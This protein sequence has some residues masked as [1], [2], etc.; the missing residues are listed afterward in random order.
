MS[1]VVKRHYP[2]HKL[3]DDLQEA[4]AGATSVSVTLERDDDGLQPVS[5]DTIRKRIEGYRQRPDFKPVST[6]ES[7]ERI[8]AL[9]DEWD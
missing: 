5:L 6:E 3:P 2:V 1:K 7:V 4:V 8:R 9:R